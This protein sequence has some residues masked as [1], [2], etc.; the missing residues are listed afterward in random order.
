MD[1]HTPWMR[2]PVV[3]VAGA[4]ALLGAVVLDVALKDVDAWSLWPYVRAE[5]V[6][7]PDGRLDAVNVTVGTGALACMTSG[8]RFVLDGVSY[9][10]F[11]DVPRGSTCAP[12]TALAPR[13]YGWTVATFL[14]TDVAGALAHT[15][16]EFQYVTLA[17][18][19]HTFAAP[20]ATGLA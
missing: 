5:R 3:A 18:T 10:R 14:G 13:R 11:A 19:V 16:I 6:H 1:P 20:L 7:R 8:P 4:A 15:T 17:G 9:R 12:V 2:A